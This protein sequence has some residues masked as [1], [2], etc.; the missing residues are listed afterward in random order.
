MTGDS[1]SSCV[2]LRSP[3]YLG[4]IVLRKIG[5]SPLSQFQ[6]PDQQPQW[7]HLT[8]L[9]CCCQKQPGE[10]VAAILSGPQLMYFCLLTSDNYVCL[11]CNVM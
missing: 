6:A 4:L 3:L 7:E 10:I 2:N 11:Y 9:E 1:G 5:G 8:A